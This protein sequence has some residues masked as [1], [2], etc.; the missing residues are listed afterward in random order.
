MLK[1]GHHGSKTSSSELFVNEVSPLYTIISAGLNNRYGHPHSDTL[2]I[3]NKF[4][5][6]ILQTMDMGMIKF[7]SDGKKL[8]LIK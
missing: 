4:E 7:K 3:L 6:K 8:I 2:N 5:Q 1:A